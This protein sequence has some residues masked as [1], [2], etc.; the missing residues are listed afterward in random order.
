M[1]PYCGKEKA[2]QAHFIWNCTHPVL[3]KAR[4]QDTPETISIMMDDLDAFP[5]H[6]L[7]GIPQAMHASFSK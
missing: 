3:M 7:Y 6:L 1:C 4:H 2:S 5:T